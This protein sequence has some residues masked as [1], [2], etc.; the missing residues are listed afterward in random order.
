MKTTIYQNIKNLRKS[1]GLTQEQLSERT[2]LSRRQIKNLKTD[3]HEP[4]FES[5]KVLASFFKSL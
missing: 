1:F 2:R 4:D 5:L 3:C